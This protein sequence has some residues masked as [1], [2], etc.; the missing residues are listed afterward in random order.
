MLGNVFEYTESMGFD[1]VEGQMTARP[2]DRIY[3]GGAWNARRAGVS[4]AQAGW[5]A[6][7]DLSFQ[8]NRGF[9]F[10]RSIRP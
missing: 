8:L 4:L 6:I 7:G 5:V 1:A 9:R 10:A 3:V 2:W